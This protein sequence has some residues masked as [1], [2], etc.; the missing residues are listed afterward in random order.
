M[1]D[2]QTAVST[3]ERRAEYE[4]AQRLA[5]RYRLEFVDMDQFPIDQ[6][7]FRSIPADLIFLRAV[8]AAGESARRRRSGPVRVADAR[9]D[10]STPWNT[11]HR[12]SRREIGY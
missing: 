7:L 3:E 11:D 9:R 10:F 12:D 4:A 2:P 6:E 8:Q 1:A 5:K